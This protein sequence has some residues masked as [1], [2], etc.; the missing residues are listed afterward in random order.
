MDGGIEVDGI[1]KQL[2]KIIGNDS[3]VIL[4]VGSYKGEDSLLFLDIFKRVR[5]FCFEP[6]PDNCN[7]H[8]KCVKD[9]RCRLI[10]TAISD[11]DEKII[12]HR[13]SSQRYPGRRASGSLRRP[14]DH[15][16]MHPWC[17]FVDDITVPGITLD[18]WC[19][20]NQIKNIDLI[21]VDVNGAEASMIAGA[22]QT[23]QHTRYLYTEFGS[24]KLEIY[25]GGITK[26]QIK[27]LLPKFKEI[28]VHSN[29]VLLKNTEIIL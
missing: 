8:R 7:D 22:K 17:T 12:F 14:K 25:E 1:I 10:E 9:E 3:P 4:E 2:S 24:D 16:W 23:L 13:S 6:D 18:T 21:W 29:N 15:R 28:L 5:L 11:K 27:N 26:N 19:Q 20:Q